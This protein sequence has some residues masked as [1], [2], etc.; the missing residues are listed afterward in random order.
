[1]IPE[2]KADGAAEAAAEA[3]AE[4]AAEARM[5]DRLTVGFDKEWRQQILGEGKTRA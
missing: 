2:G 5:N 4:V 1:V 3:A